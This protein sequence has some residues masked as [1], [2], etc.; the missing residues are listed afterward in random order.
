MTRLPRYLETPASQDKRDWYKHAI[1]LADL[2]YHH[3]GVVVLGPIPNRLPQGN[4][5]VVN[6]ELPRLFLKYLSE[7]LR[8]GAR[9]H[10]TWKASRCLW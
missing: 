5:L 6:V 3:R 7:K 10:L 9:L 2:Q 4:V 8:G 1:S